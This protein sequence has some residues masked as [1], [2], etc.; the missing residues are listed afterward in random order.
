MT[1]LNEST[2]EQAALDW[3]GPFGWRVAQGPDIAPDT[4]GAERHNYGQVV[5]DRRLRDALTLLNPSLPASALDETVR[6]LTQPEGATLE[7]RNRSFHRMLI[8]GVN[9]DYRANDGAIRGDQARV[10]DLDS[11]ENNNWLAVNQFTVT[12]NQSTRRPDVVLF[13]N[14]LPLGIIELKNPADG[15][16][17]SGPPG[18]SYRPTRPN[19]PPCFP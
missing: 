9:V 14:G 15:D 1:T 8:N 7:T 6:K 16:A 18:S 5:L 2:V 4:P 13:L 12:E 10:I 3:L 19:C 11:P 17:P